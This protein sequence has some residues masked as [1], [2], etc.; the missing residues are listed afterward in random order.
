MWASTNFKTNAAG[1][2]GPPGRRT[3]ASTRTV[4]PKDQ[5]KHHSYVPP[6]LRVTRTSVAWT[7]PGPQQTTLLTR[8]HQASWKPFLEQTDAK[9]LTMHNVSLPGPSYSTSS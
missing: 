5:N 1:A 8:S 9:S 4:K 2:A 3:K 6:K 7:Q